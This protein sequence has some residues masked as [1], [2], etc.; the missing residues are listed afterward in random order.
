MEDKGVITPWSSLQEDAVVIGVADRGM[1]VWMNGL[2]D[3]RSDPIFSPHGQG[4]YPRGPT[5]S[6][7]SNTCDDTR[8]QPCFV[9]TRTVGD[10]SNMLARGHA[11]RSLTLQI[12]CCRRVDSGESIHAFAH[13]PYQN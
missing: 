9:H 8:Y 1:E 7:Y 4:T 3:E 5:G 11:L 12:F 6:G 10:L 13:S 2:D